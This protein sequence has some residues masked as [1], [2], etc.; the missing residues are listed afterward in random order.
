MQTFKDVFRFRSVVAFET[1]DRFENGDGAAIVGCV[2]YR[3][4]VPGMTATS[5]H[6]ILTRARGERLA[7]ARFVEDSFAPARSFRESGT[8]RIRANPD[9]SSALDV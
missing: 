1:Q 4:N 8:C 2:T 7:C 5:L 3:S 6:A 9:D